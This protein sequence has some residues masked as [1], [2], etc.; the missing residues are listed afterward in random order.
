MGFAGLRDDCP[1]VS[2]K[3]PLHPPLW[4]RWLPLQTR[5]AIRLHFSTLSS[6]RIQRHPSPS[7]YLLFSILTHRLHSLLPLAGRAK[8]S[9]INGN[10]TPADRSRWNYFFLSRR[11]ASHRRGDI[12]CWFACTD[13]GTTMLLT[14]AEWNLIGSLPSKNFAGLNR[15]AP[16][17]IE[18]ISIRRSRCQ[19]KK[20]QF[21]CPFFYVK[22]DWL[23]SIVFWF[24]TKSSKEFVRCDNLL[25]FDDKQ[26]VHFI[27]HLICTIRSFIFASLYLYTLFH[28]SFVGL[29]KRLVYQDVTRSFRSYSFE[30]NHHPWNAR[31]LSQWFELHRCG[32][33]GDVRDIEKFSF[34]FSNN[35]RYFV[36]VRGLN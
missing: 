4:P 12:Y 16:H 19:L 30:T 15:G 34:L 35:F 21:Y 8:C 14:A 9:R 32:Y 27:Y 33:C 36:I 5:R 31:F 23:I 26:I 24:Y 25:T 29:I 7:K 11:R 20:L 6:H 10:V 18:D 13:A 1:V 17:K 3:P 22:I 28:F 2:A